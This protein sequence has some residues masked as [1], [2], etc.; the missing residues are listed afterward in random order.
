MR[1]TSCPSALGQNRSEKV[2]GRKISSTPTSWPRPRSA[3]A[4][5]FMPEAEIESNAAAAVAHVATDTSRAAFWPGQL[6]PVKAKFLADA[7]YNA[8]IKGLVRSAERN[9]RLPPFVMDY[10][11]DWAFP[12]LLLFVVEA[13]SA[14]RQPLSKCCAL[15]D[16]IPVFNRTVPGGC[17]GGAAGQIFKLRST[18]LGG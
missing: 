14:I 12:S 2:S 7:A 4:V 11:H 16:W 8:R 18:A 9:F 3:L 15:H 10:D 5:G 1:L 17:I 6:G 13:T